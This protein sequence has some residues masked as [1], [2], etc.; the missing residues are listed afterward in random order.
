MT[1]ENFKYVYLEL[2]QDMLNAAS[3]QERLQQVYFKAK[4]N[5]EAAEGIFYHP[6]DLKKV[7]GI[8]DKTVTALE[9]KLEKYCRE[10][11]KEFPTYVTPN[12]R[13]GNAPRRTVT[14]LQSDQNSNT[15][16]GGPV[17]KKRKYIPKQKSGGYAILLGLLEL[18][19][20]RR[21]VTKDEI[22]GV[23]Q[24]Y[25]GSSMSS[26]PSSGEFY[27]AWSS[28][29]SLLKNSLVLEEGR[30]KRYTLTTEGIELAKTLKSTGNIVFENE[31]HDHQ[32]HEISL[33]L[34]NERT[35]NL[36][37]LLRNEEGIRR[38]NETSFASALSNISQENDR[39]MQV[40]TP[41]RR[42]PLQ[43]TPT[44]VEPNSIDINKAH[45]ASPTGKIHMN[46]KRFGGI[47]YEIWRKGTY[48]IRPMID[49][50]EVKSRQEREFFS[51]AMNRKGIKM[52]TRQLALGDIIWVAIH[53]KTKF[54]CVLNTIIERKRLDDLAASIKDN[55]F[56][57]QK[58]RLEKSG[59]SQKYYLIEETMQ[60][61]VV[62]MAEA[63]KTALWM[64]LIYYRFSVIRT[65]NST[66]TVEKLYVLDSI[67]KHHYHKKDLLVMYPQTLKDQNEYTKILKKFQM[68][69]S[70]K[71]NLECCHTINTFQEIM[72]KNDSPTIGELTVQIL[73]YVNGVSL[74]KAIAIQSVFPTLNHI[75]T[76][77]RNCSSELEAKMLMFHKLGDAPGNKKITKSLSE[78]ISEIFI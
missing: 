60:S 75:L 27:G 64:I 17:R 2:L 25:A 38:I 51:E 53:K 19:A 21:P 56:M 29:G 78:K 37:E 47:S 11:G 1:V 59:C 34:E 50:R 54:C 31:K 8:G 71:T 32:D 44:S 62:N 73:M 57:E 39:S 22:V 26:N 76:A 3:H 58:N 48:D 7:K 16:E 20:V 10:N 40:S 63:L 24:K 61:S 35:M 15:K 4:A 9:N 52:E 12:I 5:L 28:I 41:E 36:S 30:P 68:E 13:P 46:R 65:M 43:S 72:G 77:Y 45:V 74:E 6:K 49:Y 69:F 66:D 33:D 70:D 18:N 23:S 55:R 42:K 14:A 67:V